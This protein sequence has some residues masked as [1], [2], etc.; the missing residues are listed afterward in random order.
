MQGMQFPPFRCGAHPP[1]RPPRP[2][3]PPHAACAT[4]LVWSVATVEVDWDAVCAKDAVDAPR[5]VA[6]A[7]CGPVGA[8]RL[9]PA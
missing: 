6:E 8:Q 1:H 5:G 9:C 7:A 4:N 3:A 2:A